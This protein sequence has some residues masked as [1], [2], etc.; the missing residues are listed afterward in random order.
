MILTMKSHSFTIVD[1]HEKSFRFHICLKYEQA[2]TEPIFCFFLGGGVLLLL[3]K[4]HLQLKRCL[5]WLDGGN[6]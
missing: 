5:Y 4:K 2:F 6:S 3:F 1:S